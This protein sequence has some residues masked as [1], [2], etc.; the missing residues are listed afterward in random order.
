[1]YDLAGLASD[2]LC[3]ECG[4]SIARS[5]TGDRLSNADT[6]WLKKIY[7]GFRL[8]IF[9]VLVP[10]LT[11][12]VMITIGLSLTTIQVYASNTWL[13][14]LMGLLNHIARITLGTVF[15]AAPFVALIG[16]F[17]A[18]TPEP[19]RVEEPDRR[20]RVWARWTAAVWLVVSVLGVAG[21]S[22]ANLLIP[23]S[24][25]VHPLIAWGVHAVVSSLHYW[26]A[27]E[28]VRS[29]ANRIPN[30]KLVRKAR[31]ERVGLVVAT[32]VGMLACGL[33]PLIAFIMYLSILD[34]LR[35]S[36]KPLI[37]PKGRARLARLASDT[38]NEST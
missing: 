5:L 2:S 35:G 24:T 13:S 6:A 19:D 15:I 17:M 28:F 7:K 14:D 4:M 10:I 36:I 27:M 1:M 26:F 29:L 11:S 9:A 23:N 38:L 30:P 37:T 21:I 8:V 12:L 22:V 33:G 31:T 18:T 34:A 3:P 32:T 16:W 25:G 20:E